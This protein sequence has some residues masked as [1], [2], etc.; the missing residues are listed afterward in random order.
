MEI[1]PKKRSGHWRSTD[2][3]LVDYINPI[4]LEACHMYSEKEVLY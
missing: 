2:L 1:F 3:E 4:V